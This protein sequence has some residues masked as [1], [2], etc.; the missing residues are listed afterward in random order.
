MTQP[1]VLCS[2]CGVPG[3]SRDRGHA[4]RRLSALTAVMDGS[5]DR[6]LVRS[7]VHMDQSVPGE[8][9]VGISTPSR[10]LSLL[11]IVQG[12]ASG[13][14]VADTPEEGCGF[15]ESVDRLDEAISVLQDEA[16]AV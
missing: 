3:L 8:P 2:P 11:K 10:G 7:A 13:L 14:F 9:A 15:A 6:A 5:R 16:Q 12:P 1:P 4:S